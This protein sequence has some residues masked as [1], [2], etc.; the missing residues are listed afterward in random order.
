[1]ELIDA[2]KYVKEL[3]LQNSR[4]AF[5]GQAE[6]DLIARDLSPSETATQTNVEQS[7]L[8]DK[9]LVS[10]VSEVSDQRRQDVLHS[11][12]LAQ[13]AANKKFPEEDQIKDWYE[14][15]V[16]VLNNIGW[17]MQSASFTPFT[18]EG[19]TIE[20][21]K[22]IID[23][24]ES[25]VGG[26]ALVPLVSKTLEAIKG[27]SDTSGKFIAFEKN[28]HTATKGAFQIGIAKEENDTVAL[29][30]GTFLITSS[31]TINQILFFKSSKSKT[32]LEF[33]SRVGTLDEAVYANVR[34]IVL[35]KLGL[36]VTQFIAG[37]DLD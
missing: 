3:A 15:F 4:E 7:F 20:V 18:S 17:A 2:K 6:L 10:F 8:N 13:L 22:A 9:S 24:V 28:T 25:A 12:L 27:L 29:Q 21:D 36:K 33:C 35:N 23:L 31:D 26:A 14:E 11:V 5:I 30:L 34:D 19:A 37:I 32:T 1:M 16:N